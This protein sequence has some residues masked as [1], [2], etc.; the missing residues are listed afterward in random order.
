[1]SSILRALVSLGLCLTLAGCYGLLI[2][3]DDSLGSVAGKIFVRTVMF[4]P[5]I[6]VSELT[7]VDSQNLE[8]RGITRWPPRSR[9]SCHE[10]LQVYQDD[11]NNRE[12]KQ[13]LESAPFLIT[14]VIVPDYIGHAQNILRQLGRPLDESPMLKMVRASLSVCAKMF[15]DSFLLPK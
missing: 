12:R 15:G 13:F 8:R 11:I 14:S 1:M 5:T 3:D 4:V 6:G 10:Y 2:H 9:E 7:L